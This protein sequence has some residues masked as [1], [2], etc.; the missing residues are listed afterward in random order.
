MKPVNEMA[1]GY[2]RFRFPLR[3]GLIDSHVVPWKGYKYM[4]VFSAS[5]RFWLYGHGI[6]ATVRI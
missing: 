2:S 1:F 5:L 3:S 6:R 4:G